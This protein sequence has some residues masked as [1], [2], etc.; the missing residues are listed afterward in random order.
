[1]IEAA[2]H[3]QVAGLILEAAFPSIR[4]VARYYAFSLPVDYFLNS[5]FDSLSK[6]P[7]L[8]IPIAFVHA[9]RDPVIPF[10][11]GRQLFE[12][13]AE[14]KRFFSVDGEIHEGAMLALG[15]EQA[16]QLREFLFTKH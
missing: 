14:P 5:R 3:E 10:Y 1:T 15:L 13:A 4:T 7:D 6:I 8:H 12:A 9:K 11:L 16:K 2:S